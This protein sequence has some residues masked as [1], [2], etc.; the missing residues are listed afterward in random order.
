MNL[1]WSAMPAETER[2]AGEEAE[3]H[4]RRGIAFIAG[5]FPPRVCG[6]GDYTALLAAELASLGAPVSVWTRVG[7]T[8]ARAGVHPVITGW[9]RAGV[10][11]LVRKLRDADPLAVHLQYERAVF[12]HSTA[13]TLLLPELLRALGVPLITTFHALDGPRSWGRAHR[14]ALLP[15]LMQSRSVVVCSPRQQQAL[16]RLPG[17]RGKVRLIPVGPTVQPPHSDTA[18]IPHRPSPPDAPVKL[19]YF[20]F[21]WPGRNVETLLQT[22]AILPAGSAMLDIVGGVRDAT[23]RAELEAMARNLGV[24]GRVTFHGEL[25]PEAVSRLLTEADIALLPFATGA[26]VGRSTLATVLAHGLPV[27]TTSVPENLSPALRHGENMLLVPAGDEAGFTRA[28]RELVESPTR[29]M[30]LA[31]GACDLARTQFAWSA[32]AQEML[33]LPAYRAVAAATQPRGR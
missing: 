11:D 15:L 9:D 14:A 20:G 31:S 10:R 28:V 27:V 4:S 30:R 3:P 12:D 16:S 2:P 25:P 5:S 19:I 8:P 13:V 21:L 32:I 17:I 22:V 26:S 6:V 24:S 18:P 1:S 7:E 33:A 23:Y 29:R